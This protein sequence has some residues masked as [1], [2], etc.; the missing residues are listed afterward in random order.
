MA[1]SLVGGSPASMAATNAACSASVSAFTSAQSALV[2]PLVRCA[3]CF[4]ASVSP[5][6]SCASAWFS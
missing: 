4:Q 3:D 5:H 1:A 2:Y 6:R